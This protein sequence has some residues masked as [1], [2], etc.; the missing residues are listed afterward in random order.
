MKAKMDSAVKQKYDNYPTAAQHFFQTIRN[1]I[2]QVA[3]AEGLGAVEETLKWNEP[4]YSTKNG[5]AIRIDLKPKSPN[6]ISIYFN[7]NTTLVE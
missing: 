3:E 6:Q 7:C 1:T 4:S 5:S 2:F